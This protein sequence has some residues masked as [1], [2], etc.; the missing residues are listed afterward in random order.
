[1]HWLCGAQ[2]ADGSWPPGALNGV[3]FGTGMLHYQL[4]PAYFPVWALGRYLAASARIAPV[5]GATRGACRQHPL[6][7]DA[8]AASAAAPRSMTVPAGK[9]GESDVLRPDTLPEPFAWLGVE[10]APFVLRWAF[11]SRWWAGRSGRGCAHA[12]VRRST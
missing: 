6:P 10:L 5:P 4:Y 9:G 8:A 11:L 2:R 1:M 7:G 3:F 12:E